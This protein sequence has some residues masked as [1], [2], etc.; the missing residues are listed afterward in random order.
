MHNFKELKIW[1]RSMELVKDIYL[2]TKS[3]PKDEKFELV[4]QIKRATVSIPSNIAEGSGRGTS[5]DFRRFLAISLSSAYELETQII[6]SNILGFIN[7]EDFNKVVAEI[8]EIQKIIFSF[9]KSLSI[10]T[11]MHN[12]LISFFY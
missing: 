11:K 1:Q 6:L 2:I 9:R 12:F 3:F 4:S 8:N 7:D 10:T 5:K